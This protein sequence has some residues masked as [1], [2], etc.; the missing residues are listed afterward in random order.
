MPKRQE[1]YQAALTLTSAGAAYDDVN[2]ERVKPGK[3]LRVNLV[4]VENYTT[5]FT[6]LRI[7]VNN[8]GNISWYGEEKSPVA[9]ELY[10]LPEVLMVPEGASLTVR[11]T[12]CTSGDLLRVNIQGFYITNLPYTEE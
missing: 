9:A 3:L 8:R 4:G 5:D 2:S 12:G 10:W 11:F 7:G 6:S 1:L